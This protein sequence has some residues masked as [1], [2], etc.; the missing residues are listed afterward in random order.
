MLAY[1]MAG[2]LYAYENHRT[3]LST[4]EHIADK[5]FF[6]CVSMFLEYLIQ[7]KANENEI[8]ERVTAIVEAKRLLKL[9]NGARRAEV[10]GGITFARYENFINYKRSDN[11]RDIDA[12]L[13]LL[14]QCNIVV[15]IDNKIYLNP[16][17]DAMEG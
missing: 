4:K 8:K 14:V 17:I 6:N 11:P 2:T 5:S 10:I 15:I 12:G 7:K 3:F 13:E 9:F 1:I 16:K